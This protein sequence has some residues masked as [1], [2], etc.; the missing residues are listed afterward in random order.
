M[1]FQDAVSQNF[2]PIMN[3]LNEAVSQKFKPTMK[4]L[5]INYKFSKLVNIC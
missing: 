5:T 2:K 1:A 3:M 4:K